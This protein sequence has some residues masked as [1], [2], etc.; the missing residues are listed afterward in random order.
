M[1]RTFAKNN[2]TLV[3]IILFLIFF[4]VVQL[5]KPNFMYNKNGS[6][7]EFGVGYNNKTI[8]PVWLFSVI[9]GILTYVLVLYYVTYQNIIH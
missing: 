2:T 6:L 1:L 5:I 4:C 8:L 7:R 3:S 9:L